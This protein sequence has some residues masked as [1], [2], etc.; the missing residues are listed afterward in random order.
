MNFSYLWKVE[1]HLPDQQKGKRDYDFV[2]QWRRKDGRNM[3]TRRGDEARTEGLREGIWQLPLIHRKGVENTTF[4]N[5]DK[6]KGRE[7][8]KAKKLGVT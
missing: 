4:P 3:A 8:L 1:R 2:F 6:I 5:A 7:I